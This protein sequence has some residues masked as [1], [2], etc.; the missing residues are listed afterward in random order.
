MI[1]HI[2][3]L[4]WPSRPISYHRVYP[5]VCFFLVFFIS[6]TWYSSLTH[7]KSEYSSTSFACY[8]SHTKSITVSYFYSLTCFALYNLSINE[9]S[10]FFLLTHLLLP[11]HQVNICIPFLLT[12][13]LSPHTLSIIESL[14]FFLFHLNHILWLPNPFWNNYP[15][16]LIPHLLHLSDLISNYPIFNIT[17]LLW[18]CMN[19]LLICIS[20][21]AS[22]N[23][24]KDCAGLF[25]LQYIQ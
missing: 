4:F 2:T 5:F 22:I 14:L 18:P 13:M 24:V 7:L 8:G 23:S 6:H 1:F 12:N 15:I 10:F 20:F 9:S 17:H 25:G 16:S 19:C 3:Q 11:S 21:S